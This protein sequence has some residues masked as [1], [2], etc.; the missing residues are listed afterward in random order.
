M[1]VGRGYLNARF[2]KSSS[3]LV[4]QISMFKWLTKRGLQVEV[5]EGKTGLDLSKKGKMLN[6]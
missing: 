6:S 4:N 2:H 1:K 3:F 5:I